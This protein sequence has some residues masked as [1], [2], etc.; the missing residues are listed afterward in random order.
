MGSRNKK[1]EYDRI[2]SSNG[3]GLNQWEKILWMAICV[4]WLIINVTYIYDLC[5][6]ID[7]D[8]NILVKV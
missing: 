8:V 4:A 2:V 1:P 5:Y 3:R 6:S 7:I